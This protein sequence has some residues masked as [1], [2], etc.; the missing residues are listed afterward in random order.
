MEHVRPGRRDL[1]SF[2]SGNPEL[3]D[4]FRHADRYALETV[5]RAHIH[6]VDRYLRSRARRYRCAELAQSGVMADIVQ[7]VFVRAFSSAGRQG[8]DGVRDYS[9]YL[10]AIA[11][12]CFVDALRARGREVVTSPDDLVLIINEVDVQPEEWCEPRTQE[13]M[14]AYLEALSPPLRQVCRHRFVLEH[15]QEETSA[16]LGLSRRTVRTAEN[17]VR[18]G[19][20]KAFVRAGISMRELG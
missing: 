11:R 2:F 3:L 16:S 10:A 7:E 13:V 19:L 12:N 6:S 4:G 15:S 17:H 20:R 18:D 1:P 14:V 5:Y 8:Y 9:L